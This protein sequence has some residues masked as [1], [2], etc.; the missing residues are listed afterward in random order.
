MALEL[1]ACMH[2]AFSRRNSKLRGSRH[3]TND[4][5]EEKNKMEIHSRNLSVVR[6][7]ARPASLLCSMWHLL[8]I[9]D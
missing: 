3:G 9:P 8:E 2:A 1:Q 4:V 5:N 7:L 6:S